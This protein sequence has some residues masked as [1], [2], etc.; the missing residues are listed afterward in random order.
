LPTKAVIEK[1]D[2]QNDIA[3]AHLSPFDCKLA[4]VAILA[5]W[6]NKKLRFRH[7]YCACTVLCLRWLHWKCLQISILQLV[8]ISTNLLLSRFTM[9]VP[10]WKRGFLSWPIKH[11]SS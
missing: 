4:R 1:L 7:A 6:G 11:V 8:V 2:T 10:L 9:T 5:G 3:L